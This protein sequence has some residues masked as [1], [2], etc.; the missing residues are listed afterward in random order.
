MGG[1]LW[2]IKCILFGQM[3]YYFGG[4]FCLIHYEKLCPLQPPCLANRALKKLIYNYITTIPWKYEKL[5]FKKCQIRKSRNCT[6]VVS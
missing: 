3:L 6:I 1:S 5:I 4:N 2:A